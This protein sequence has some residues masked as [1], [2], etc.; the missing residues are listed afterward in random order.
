MKKPA[1]LT[2]RLSWTQVSIR[3]YGRPWKT[4]AVASKNLST[5]HI[6]Q[7]HVASSQQPEMNSERIHPHGIGML[8]ATDGNMATHSLDI[9]VAGEVAE[10]G[11]HVGELP[12]TFLGC[13]LEGW[14]AWMDVRSIMNRWALFL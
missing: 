10:S 5:I 6:H 2:G 7:N 12:V 1:R 3:N 11:G 14:E 9:I 4:Y 13:Q 8:L